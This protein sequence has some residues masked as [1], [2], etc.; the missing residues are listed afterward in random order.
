MSYER[1]TLH[2]LITFLNKRGFGPSK[3]SVL[4]YVK[5][6]Y[7]MSSR[8][9]P[10]S[11]KAKARVYYHP[12][13][14][15]EIMTTTLLFKG[16]FLEPN[17][18]VRLPRFNAEQL[19]YAR[20]KFYASYCEKNNQDGLTPFNID[21]NNFSDFTDYS[22]EYPLDNCQYD[23]DLFKLDDLS[24]EML[25]KSLEGK[26]VPLREIFQTMFYTCTV[27]Y[28]NTYL[29]LLSKYREDLLLYATKS[30]SDPT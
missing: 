22:F 30:E 25:E 20:L 13:T 1:F 29:L 23:M 17:S 21:K 24:K 18:S 9:I 10:K 8:R 11:G 16:D 5:E 7:A 3:S 4:R 15:I 19:F 26:E 27:A 6:G 14:A 2:K 28:K 12:L